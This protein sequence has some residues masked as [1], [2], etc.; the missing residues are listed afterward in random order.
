MAK[1]ST[2]GLSTPEYNTY[3][4]NKFNGVDY[5]TT[6]TSV[7]DTRA[8]DMSNYLPYNNSLIKRNGY[9]QI[10]NYVDLKNIWQLNE[11][12]VVYSDNSLYIVKSLEEE[13][14]TPIKTDIIDYGYSYGTVNCNRLFL[15]LGK[16]YLMVYKEDDKY[17]CKN[18][19]DEAF[20]P[21][22]V[23]GAG[24]DV[25]TFRPTKYQS[26]N[27]LT[28]K[29][30][31]ELI[32][33]IGC[34]PNV[35]FIELENGRSIYIAPD[36]IYPNKINGEYSKTTKEENGYSY[37]ALSVY[38]KAY[39]KSYDYKTA[40][41]K[42]SG[43]Y[44]NPM[45]PSLEISG[46]IYIKINIEDNVGKELDFYTLYNK[47]DRFLEKS[48]AN[49][50]TIDSMTL[51]QVVFEEIEIEDGYKFRIF[52]NANIEF[53]DSIGDD[54]Y[55]IFDEKNTYFAL[56]S[57]KEYVNIALDNIDI[58]N[59]TKELV[60]DRAESE[61]PIKVEEMKFGMK[62]GINNNT[63]VLFL[64]GDDNYK[65]IDIHS[66]NTNSTSEEQWRDFTYF[67][68]DNYQL[69]GNSNSAIVGYGLI[70]NG[71]M[72]VLKENQPN[73]S[74]LYLR[75]A[76][77]LNT[78][79][80]TSTGY[81]FTKYQIAYPI[82]TSGINM[83]GKILGVINYSSVLIIHTNKGLYR[84]YAGD[85]TATQTYEV[86][87][88]SYNI[89]NDLDNRNIEGADIIQ[90][91]GLLYLTRYSVYGKKRIY[92]ADENRYL[93]NDS[94]LTYEWWTLDDIDSVKL[95]NLNN[96]LYFLN[97]NV[98]LC[99]F[100]VEEDLDEYEDT[101]VIKLED[102][103]INGNSLSKEA[104]IINK[105]LTLSTKSKV[106]QKI[107]RDK[108][109]YKRYNDLLHECYITFECDVEFKTPNL[110]TYV[111]EKGEKVKI[112]E[113]YATV[114][115]SLYPFTKCSI[116]DDIVYYKEDILGRLDDVIFNQL[117]V[118]YERVNS[119]SGVN[120]LYT[121]SHRGVINGINFH[122]NMPVYSYWT[123]KYNDLGYIGILKSCERMTFIPDFRIGGKTNVGY[124]TVK[125]NIGYSTSALVY[126]F[127][128][129][130][131]N[132]HDFGTITTYTSKKKIKNFTLL[133]IQFINEN[134][135]VSSIN[136]LDIRYKYTKASKGAL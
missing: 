43:R 123:G 55:F 68:D 11:I 115:D 128:E 126:N 8:I 106:I 58:A 135:S 77:L 122:C 23:L 120:E 54:E 41:V 116:K 129:I 63:D 119:E 84:L 17:V 10:N 30:K 105:K 70:N 47:V 88:L 118:K 121:L 51:M 49:S 76:T 22:I 27:L 125:K 82:T 24:A 28:T 131:F 85:S 81:T 97:E 78:D 69:F 59:Y 48:G 112:T 29:Y 61:L 132:A 4:L 67:P 108:E 20:V 113:L 46:D 18:V 98:G 65:H 95:F 19:K 87:E 33:P 86:A 104:S 72:L 93:Y 80:T 127:D 83:D 12:Y 130:D 117:E 56:F 25:S 39:N 71:Q 114:D 34:E 16:Q 31:I 111:V 102:A 73:E 89:R 136:E 60:L 101:Y 66:G 91:N 45:N 15:L 5:T 75:T 13:L 64:A 21:T 32:E 3:K 133:Q 99:T 79:I 134:K 124:R 9:K 36:E 42:V 100:K 103:N 96:T 1:F 52:S 92:V 2:S 44:L 35:D 7:D 90:N 57:K 50:R 107:T 37:N 6:P 62:Y 74:N 38:S 14:K 110:E 40:V 94:K 26:F 53:S 109:V